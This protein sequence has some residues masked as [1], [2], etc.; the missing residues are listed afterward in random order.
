MVQAT[1]EI[2]HISLLAS[3]SLLGAVQYEDFIRKTAIASEAKKGTSY[4][5]HSIQTVLKLSVGILKRTNF[6]F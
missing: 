5:G 6:R 4:R 3:A 2:I 1:D